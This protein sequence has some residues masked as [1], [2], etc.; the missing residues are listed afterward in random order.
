MS[1]SVWPM[2]GI[3]LAMVDGLVCVCV[4]MAVNTVLFTR[5]KKFTEKNF[6]SRRDGAVK[7]TGARR[8]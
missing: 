7:R 5:E 8:G 4:P 1:L 2:L 3:C 6:I